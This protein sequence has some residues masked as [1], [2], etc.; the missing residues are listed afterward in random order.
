[1][2]HG[3]IRCKKTKLFLTKN[4]E[5]PKPA[6]LRTPLSPFF[7]R[8]RKIAGC[9]CQGLIPPSRLAT[10]KIEKE[11]TVRKL[12][13]ETS[14]VLSHSQQICTGESPL[15]R[16][17]PSSHW[18]KDNFESSMQNSIVEI[19]MQFPQDSNYPGIRI[20]HIRIKREVPVF[21]CSVSFSTEWPGGQS[22]LGLKTSWV[23]K[24]QKGG[25]QTK[26]KLWRKL[27]P[28][29]YLDYSANHWCVC[30]MGLVF[31]TGLRLL[32]GPVATNV[33]G[34][35]PMSPC[36]GLDIYPG[37]RPRSYHSESTYRWVLVNP[38]KQYQVKIVNSG[39]FQIL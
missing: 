13:S 25:N 4:L 10:Q 6:I 36:F 18:N 32:W 2:L 17:I 27:E 3:L 37:L 24:C 22:Q 5:Y 15:N 34:F 26:R 30:G 28:L 7:S 23:R 8:H 29:F 31:T 9:R 11:K 14:T 16:S 21:F 20:I 1:M 35:C 19:E 38:N 39:E 12:H 33:W